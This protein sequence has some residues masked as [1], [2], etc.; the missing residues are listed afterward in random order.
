MLFAAAQMA[1]TDLSLLVT[2]TAFIT[3]GDCCRFCHRR[4]AIFAAF[5]SL[6]V[7]CCCFVKAGSSCGF[8]A[9]ACYCCLRRC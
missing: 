5:L 9:T 1:V 6:L 8:S 7:D 4:L 2:V 3:T